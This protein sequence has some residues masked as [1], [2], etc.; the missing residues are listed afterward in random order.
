VVG[1]EQDQGMG[2]ATSLIEEAFRVSQ[3]HALGAF[4]DA[5]VE[6]CVIL[7]EG[8]GPG[9][10]RALRVMAKALERVKAARPPATKLYTSTPV[11]GTL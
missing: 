8:A 9:G 11:P 1:I 5:L 3:A 10:E 2:R 7:G 4:F 6:D